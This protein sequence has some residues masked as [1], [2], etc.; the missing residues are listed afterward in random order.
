MRAVASHKE[1]IAYQKAYRLVLEIYQVTKGFPAEEL[2][3]LTGQ[4]RRSAVSI[5]SNIAEGYMRGTKEY[6][7]F[8][9]VA[10]GSSAELDTQLSFGRDLGYIGNELFEQLRNELE[11]VINL[12]RSYLKKLTNP[13]YQNDKSR[14]SI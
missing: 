3:G 6:A 7:Q 8:L 4:M 14:I 5:P 10:L 2:Y 12:L 11:E 1:L 9:R 13:N